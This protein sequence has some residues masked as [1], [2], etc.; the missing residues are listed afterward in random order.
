MLCLCISQEPFNDVDAEY[1]EK[2]SQQLD[3]ELRKKCVYNSP[4]TRVLMEELFEY[5]TIRLNKS[6]TANQ[7]EADDVDDKYVISITARPIQYV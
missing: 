6:V 5:I 4:R 3:T 1:N 7:L 2:M